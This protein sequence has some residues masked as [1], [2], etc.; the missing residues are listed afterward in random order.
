MAQPTCLSTRRQSAVDTQ[1]T[2]S[3]AD[4]RSECIGRRIEQE[5]KP[6][7]HFTYGLALCYVG[8]LTNITEVQIH[9]MSE[10]L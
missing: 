8:E 6:R 7:T 4:T 9:R 5:P 3:V 1:L 10:S 2:R